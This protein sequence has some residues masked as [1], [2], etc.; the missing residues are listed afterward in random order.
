M[1]CQHW[2]ILW[3]CHNVVGWTFLG[4][5]ERMLALLVHNLQMQIFFSFVIHFEHVM[6]WYRFNYPWRLWQCLTP[7]FR[8]AGYLAVTL[9]QRSPELEPLPLSPLLTPVH[10]RNCHN[11]GG[12]HPY[13]EG[14]DCWSCWCTTCSCRNFFSCDQLWACGVFLVIWLSVDTGTVSDK[15]VQRCWILRC[16]TVTE[17]SCGR[18]ISIESA[19]NTGSPL[20]LP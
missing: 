19:A 13:G 18:A 2:F 6:Y 4:R 16:S 3:H 12:D 15:C 9:W 5:R 11:V 20:A 1:H 17:E 14:W 8:V 10:L 7:V